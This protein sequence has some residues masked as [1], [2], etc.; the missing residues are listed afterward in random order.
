M[1]HIFNSNP[2]LYDSS[3]VF[4][5]QERGLL[6]FGHP[7]PVK[8]MRCL[9]NYGFENVHLEYHTDPKTG[10]IFTRSLLCFIVNVIMIIKI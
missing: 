7:D 10:D 5:L 3:I 4:N 9:E 8:Y 1:I 2:L 6:K